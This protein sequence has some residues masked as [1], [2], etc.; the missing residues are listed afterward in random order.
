MD[1]DGKVDSVWAVCEKNY[2]YYRTVERYS[3]KPSKCL[4]SAEL[5]PTGLLPRTPEFSCIDIPVNRAGIYASS[6]ALP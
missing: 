6:C 3:K 5:N 1:T 2:S 4:V